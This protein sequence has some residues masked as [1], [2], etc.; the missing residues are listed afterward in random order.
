MKCANCQTENDPTEL[1]CTQCGKSL[2]R[3]KEDLERVDPRSTETIGIAV[4]SMGLIGLF[5]VT[6]NMNALTLSGL[7][8][9]VPVLLLVVGTGIIAYARSLKK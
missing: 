2:A 9:V 3:T 7:D 6:L 5:F 1:S 8:Y 4:G